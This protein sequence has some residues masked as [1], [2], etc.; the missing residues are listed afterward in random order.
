MMHTARDYLNEYFRITGIDR[1]ASI[2]AAI[3]FIKIIMD[4]GVKLD[5]MQSLYDY[6]DDWTHRGAE[7]SLMSQAKQIDGWRVGRARQ[8]HPPKKKRLVV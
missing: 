4:A 1:V 7:L 5:E 8:N 3:K 2:P 6:I